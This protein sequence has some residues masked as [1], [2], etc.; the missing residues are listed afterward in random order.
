MFNGYTLLAVLAAWPL[1][2]LIVAALN[3]RRAR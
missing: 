3:G 2:H 1:A